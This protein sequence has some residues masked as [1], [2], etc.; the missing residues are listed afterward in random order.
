MNAV[1]R[2]LAEGVRAVRAGG[3]AW[4]LARGLHDAG[5]ITEARDHERVETERVEDLAVEALERGGRQPVDRGHR[6]AQCRDRA[7]REAE[8]AVGGEVRDRRT[9]VRRADGDERA[10]VLRESEV[11]ERV[12]RVEAA[13]RFSDRG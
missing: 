9:A 13:P 6:D 1:M 2:V 11:G 4:S 8:R 3:I 5:R 12:T 10:H 7:T